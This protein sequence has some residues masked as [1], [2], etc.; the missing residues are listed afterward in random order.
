MM[1]SSGSEPRSSG[2]SVPAWALRNPFAVAAVFFGVIVAAI[3]AALFVL[4][5][6]L[7]PYVQSPLI[8]V[9]T[10]TPGYSPQEVET[11]F[12]KPIEERMTDL[13]GV[14]FVRSIS[15]PDL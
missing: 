14:H 15:Q 12:S 2:W 3:A 6:R 7:L 8:S 9:V 10:M 5:T 11:Y 13:R 4:P 1:S